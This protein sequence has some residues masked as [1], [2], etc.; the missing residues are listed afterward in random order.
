MQ[1]S[2]IVEEIKNWVNEIKD[3]HDARTRENLNLL[4]DYNPIDS[5]NLSFLNG[6]YAEEE[7]TQ[8]FLN[9]YEKFCSRIIDAAQYQSE[10]QRVSEQFTSVSLMLHL[11][12]KGF[13][14]YA[15]I[16]NKF[17]KSLIRKRLENSQ[18][19]YKALEVISHKRNAV[20][21]MIDPFDSA[22]FDIEYQIKTP[23]DAY[24]FIADKIRANYSDWEEAWVEFEP[25]VP[26]NG[27]LLAYLRYNQSL[28]KTP[29]N[30]DFE[31]NY[32]VSLLDRMLL[33]QGLTEWEKLTINIKSDG[34]YTTEFSG[35]DNVNNNLVD[36]GN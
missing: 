31:S 36:T 25:N 11:M 27:R 9:V 15:D 20:I 21:K 1:E 14:I 30:L 13:D 8:E 5:F 12:D 32:A 2:N 35:E 26:P 22:F 6:R 16:L 10:S 19:I 3:L 23:D 17:D 34:S 29:F 28:E 7:I 18:M 33:D 24:K 4:F